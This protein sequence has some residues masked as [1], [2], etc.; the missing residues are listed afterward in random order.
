MAAV[1]MRTSAASAKLVAEHLVLATVDWTCHALG[2][3][4]SWSAEM[5]TIVQVV[6]H[7]RLPMFLAWG[8]KLRMIYNEACIRSWAR[9]TS[10]PWRRLWA[11]RQPGLHLA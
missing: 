4:A 10:Q 5:L 3:L 1:E 2:Q 8:P 9:R 7:C 11:R 6:M